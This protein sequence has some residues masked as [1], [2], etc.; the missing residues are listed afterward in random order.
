MRIL[1]FTDPHCT[2]SSEFSKPTEDGYNEYLRL[3]MNSFNFVEHLAIELRPDVLAFGGDFWDDRDY[4]DT[5]A[6]NVGF[7]VWERMSSLPV[8]YKLAVVG[9]HDYFSIEH[10][11]HSLECLKSLGWYVFEQPSF[12]D[13]DETCR[14]AGVPYRDT[15]DLEE[16]MELDRANPDVVLA[17]ADVVG[18][19]RRAPKSDRDKKA[20]SDSGLP[21]TIFSNAGVVLNG[22]YHHPSRVSDNWHNIGSLTSRT[23]HDKN[24]DPRGAILYDTESREIVRYPNPHARAFVDVH[25]ESE[26]DLADLLNYD[27]SNSYA[28]IY[29]NLELEDEAQT[30][31]EMFAGARL[32]PVAKRKVQTAQTAIDLRFS[33]EENLQRYMDEQY[34]DPGL[35]GLALEIFKQ[36]AEDY[37]TD[38]SR[39]PLEF[40]W[41]EVHNYQ[42]I[43]HLKVNLHNRGLIFIR[44]INND[45]PGQEGNGSGKSSFIEA[46]YWCLKGKSLRGYTANE[47]IHW[48]EEYVRVSVEVFVGD[49]VYTIIRSRKDPE[50]GTG[51]KILVGGESAG[52]RLKTD[53]Q[54][55]LE[56]LI[57]RSEDSLKHV[58]FMTANLAN[59]FTKLTFPQR[60]RL[61]EDIVDSRPYRLCAKL[62]EEM[63]STSQLELSRVRGS[64]ETLIA[65]KDA[66]EARIAEL[67]K[68]LEEY[69]EN[70]RELREAREGEKLELE[71]NIEILTEKKDNA[72]TEV[73][74]IETALSG[75]R[76]KLA[77]LDEDIRSRE[78]TIAGYNSQLAVLNADIERL[79]RL[80]HQSACPTCEQ[81][82]NYDVSTKIS[83]IQNEVRGLR[84]VV[85][86]ACND[87]D[88]VMHRRN[89]VSG[90]IGGREHTKGDK[91]TV[92]KN[93]DRKLVTEK[94]RLGSVIEALSVLDNSRQS[95]DSQLV[96]REKELDRLQP[97][98]L[99]VMDEEEILENRES[100]LSILANE[101]FDEKGVR[102]SILSQVAIPYLN[103]RIPEYAQYLWG[104]RMLELTGSREL[105]GGR[106]K[107]DIDIIYD[108]KLTYKGCSSGEKRRV[109][110]IIQFALNDL[111]T[112]TGRSR[113]GL[114]VIDEAFDSLDESGIYAAKEALVLKTAGTILMISHSKYAAAICPRQMTFMKEGKYTTLLEDHT[115]EVMGA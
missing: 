39:E 78:V 9:N 81:P 10:N 4:V 52:A 7:K 105:K 109:D 48:H 80:L 43:G 22:H 87:R 92:I 110:L 73:D 31:R 96:E 37:A 15:Y 44:G 46:L 45:D 25:I 90:I 65:T 28:R 30:I 49:K 67:K 36:A 8:K 33:L 101:V 64:L 95:L 99:E 53:T 5:L 66:T 1:E 69:D 57:G 60:A 91:Q 85:E 2:R 89:K 86:E 16:I 58:A 56:D 115:Q 71:A 106:S 3:F 97:Q 76:A 11:I 77:I 27:H 93:C 6:L 24:S 14:I 59:R 40:G 114:L 20:Y 32:L 104:G 26:D 108:G 41:L 102:N 107:N 75:F 111:A 55:K 38:S 61:L 18:G 98:I 19:R 62:A 68:Q 21:S 12:L 84:T 100:Q 54:V 47:I 72:Q 112:A 88:R 13:L 29:Y 42:S 74:S 79:G 70:T 23:F 17:H 94:S 113:V 51:L 35:T 83:L 82:V 103:A 63:H 34:D 50:Y